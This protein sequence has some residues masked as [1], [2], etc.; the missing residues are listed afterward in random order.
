MYVCMSMSMYVGMYE[1]VNVCMYM[2]K[3]VCMSI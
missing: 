1:Y 3:Y 2:S